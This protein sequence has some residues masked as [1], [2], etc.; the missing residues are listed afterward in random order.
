MNWSDT[1]VLH[2]HDASADPLP[3]GGTG[4]VPENG[5]LFLGDSGELPYE[6]RRAACQLLSGPSVDAQRQPAQWAA[7]LRNE[8]AIRSLLSDLF[9]EL[10]LDRDAGFAFVRQADTG[11]LDTPTLLRTAPLTFI[12][13]V[14]LLFLRQQLADADTRGERAVVEE[15]Q[16]VEALSVYQRN[17]STDQAGFARRVAAAIGKMRENQLLFRLRGSEDRYEVSPA[18]KHLFSAEDVAVLAETYRQLREG[19]AALAE[20]VDE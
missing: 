19:D 1:P 16:M 14:L 9:L 8:A 17:V 2:D 4:K 20:E 12:E 11:E 6:A 5:P 3:Q 18:L 7:L 15:L 13:S 10:V